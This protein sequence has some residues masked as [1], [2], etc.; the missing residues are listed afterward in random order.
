MKY[1]LYGTIALVLLFLVLNFLNYDA[2]VYIVG[3]IEWA[4][5]Y[6]LPWIALYW[7]VQFVKIKKA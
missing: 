2:F 4:T 5:R 7:F 1:S 6:L 3:F